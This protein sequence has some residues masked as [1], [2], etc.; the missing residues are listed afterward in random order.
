MLDCAP[1]WGAA[2]ARSQET[3]LS[4]Q[5]PPYIPPSAPAAPYQGSPGA[6]QA[7]ARPPFPGGPGSGLAVAALVVGIVSL[8]G[9]VIP[10]VNVVSIVGGIIALVLGLVAL[11]AVKKGRQSGKG[12]AV[13]GVVTGVLAVIGAIIAN[14]VFAAAVSTVGAAVEEAADDVAQDAADAAADNGVAADDEPLVDAAQALPVG[15][16]A[17]VGD[18]TVTVAAVTLDGTEAVAA[19]NEFNEP[20]TN[21]YVLVDLDAVYNGAEEGDPWLDLMTVFAGSDARQYD[22]SSCE[23]ITAREGFDLPTL[24]AGGSAEWQVCLD[25][26]P[27]AM[28]GGTVFV[29]P[30]FS[31]DDTERK[32]WA[33]Q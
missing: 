1:A 8:L 5:T 11:N 14:V 12:M 17:E 29:E 31:F 30:T 28:E 19:A 16:S 33:L 26:P 13:A 27:A 23:A 3:S 10:V 25:V 9:C 24:T 4:E 32:T 15:Q 2:S 6:A 22:E 20:A 21:Q 18:Y 7:V